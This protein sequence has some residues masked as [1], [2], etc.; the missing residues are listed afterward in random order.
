MKNKLLLMSLLA[1]FAMVQAE[2]TPEQ[3]KIIQEYVHLIICSELFQQARDV[4]EIPCSLEKL[5]KIKIL[6]D[7]LRAQ[8]CPNNYYKTALILVELDINAKGECLEKSYINNQN[9]KEVH[10]RMLELLQGHDIR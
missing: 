3:E 4:D 2:I 6:E 5:E 7:K 8:K 10:L 1:S 9:R